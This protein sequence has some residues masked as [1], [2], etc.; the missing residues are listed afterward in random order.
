MFAICSYYNH[1][2]DV[3]AA[4]IAFALAEAIGFYLADSIKTDIVSHADPLR[5][6][7][8][9]VSRLQLGSVPNFCL[10]TSAKYSVRRSIKSSRRSTLSSTM[11][12][13]MRAIS[14]AP[15]IPIG[16]AR[17]A[18]PH[19]PSTRIAKRNGVIV[20]VSWNTLQCPQ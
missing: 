9:A 2:H 7:S 11:R 1:A 3:S 5:S 19:S 14:V 18:T 6:L 12:I 10:I 17:Y 8:G 4:A 15:S 13:L 16:G 20:V